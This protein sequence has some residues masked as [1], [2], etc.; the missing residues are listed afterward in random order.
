MNFSPTGTVR[1]LLV[2]IFAQALITLGLDALLDTTATLLLI[3][4][5]RPPRS[6]L[7]S[8]DRYRLI[9]SSQITTHLLQII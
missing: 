8:S 6:D 1:L 2:I 4:H 5:G 3:A 7:D 9:A